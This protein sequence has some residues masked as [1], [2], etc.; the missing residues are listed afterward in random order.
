MN[1]IIIAVLSFLS[2]SAKAQFV[3]ADYTMSKGLQK[4]ISIQ[5]NELTNEIAKN[6]FHQVVISKDPAAIQTLNANNELF[7]DNVT[8]SSIAPVVIDIYAK[9]NDVNKELVL[10][11][12]MGNA[13]VSASTSQ[14]AAIGMQQLG[15]EIKNKALVLIKQFNLDSTKRYLALLQLDLDNVNTALKSNKKEV[16][17]DTKDAAKDEKKAAKTETKL[18]ETTTTK[19]EVENN[20]TTK[21]QE[22]ANF[23]LEQMKAEIKTKEKAIKK[24]KKATKKLVK[25]NTK[26]EA[27]KAKLQAAI[28]ANNK[29]IATNRAV[30]TTD[31]N[32]VVANKKRIEDFDLKGRKKEIKKLDKKKDKLA[33]KQSQQQA[34]IEEKKK[35]AE[36]KKGNVEK[37]AKEIEELKAKQVKLETEIEQVKAKLKA[38][39]N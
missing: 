4:G 21:T 1:K 12:D 25:S 39:E 33:D 6:A 10:F 3:E 36:A 13:F 23:P 28:D 27:K 35:D 8:I 17:N 5:I 38:L 29:Q 15:V 9:Y 24:E 11:A 2:I 19:T 7:Y 31:S 14:T 37:T 32:S 18:N 16:K 26:A 20:L 30:I 34:D 22:V